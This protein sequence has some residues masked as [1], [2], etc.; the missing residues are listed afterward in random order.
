M[1][2]SCPAGARDANWSGM[3]LLWIACAVAACGQAQH[4][5]TNVH[6][7]EHVTDPNVVQ[8]PTNY[9][10]GDSVLNDQSRTGGLPTD[11]NYQPCWFLDDE[12]NKQ[13]ARAERVQAFE[14]H[15]NRVA[16]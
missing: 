3:R 10:C 14:E 9:Q 2:H 7:N 11:L 16:A 13:L 5:V 6:T 1:S 8:Q 12:P 15:D 4:G